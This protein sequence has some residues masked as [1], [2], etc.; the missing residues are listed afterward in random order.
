MSS[1]GTERDNRRFRSQ[2]Q[3]PNNRRAGSAS[4]DG[5]EPTPRRSPGRSR[6]MP[7]VSAAN[8]RFRAML[9]GNNNSGNNYPKRG[10]PDLI[11]GMNRAADH[12]VGNRYL[13]GDES[14]GASQGY[15]KSSRR[16]H[17]QQP[18][19]R[20]RNSIASSRSAYVPPN[21]FRGRSN[22]SQRDEDYKTSSA[23]DGDRP[24]SSPRVDNETRDENNDSS[25]DRKTYMAGGY[26]N[27][28][29]QSQRTLA[30]RIL[31]VEEHME[32]IAE[33][34]G[35][36]SMAL[37]KLQ[38]NQQQK[39]LT[40][41]KNQARSEALQG[42]QQIKLEE[43]QDNQQRQMDE[44]I[45]HLNRT[46]EALT[47]L[48]KTVSGHGRRIAKNEISIVALNEGTHGT[49]AV[50]D[51]QSTNTSDSTSSGIHKNNTFKRRN[52]DPTNREEGD[53]KNQQQQ[54]HQQQQQADT[55]TTG[56]A[57][58]HSFVSVDMNRGLA[59][60]SFGQPNIMGAQMMLPQRMDPVASHEYLAMIKQSNKAINEISK[61]RA[62][63][64]QRNLVNHQQYL[65][66]A[67]EDCRQVVQ[68]LAM[69]QAAAAGT[70]YGGGT[71]DGS[72][73]LHGGSIM[74]MPPPMSPTSS[75]RYAANPARVA[76]NLVDDD[77]SSG[78][79]SDL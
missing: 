37:V 24:S 39:Y 45:H 67:D 4:F 30:T 43:F 34:L 6:S 36:M 1:V 63:T 7:M 48:G 9:D 70:V 52:R 13:Y 53:I 21:G 65:A 75:Y 16:I 38:E 55:N 68:N 19:L 35:H 58:P 29:R 42:H 41:Q 14:V 3:N 2:S 28:G 33:S 77:F 32:Q 62:K 25:H 5:A 22:R 49:V 54:Q 72:S 69:A 23:S 12:D 26:R 31:C 11:R 8:R 57:V 40:L 50:G 76:M 59:P 61:R 78:S 64:H 51:N 66:S 27:E 46:L 15:S 44:T 60:N 17:D 79:G 56:R 18:P 74:S 71:D 47:S 73:T 10:S 20:Y